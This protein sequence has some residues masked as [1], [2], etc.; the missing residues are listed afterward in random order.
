MGQ[1]KTKSLIE[2][3]CNFEIKVMGEANKNFCNDIISI[4]RK[5]DLKFDSSKIE[6][7]GSSKGKYISLTCNIYATSQIQLNKI[8]TALSKNTMTK[9]VL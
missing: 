2:F 6:M 9:F 8:Y 1:E 3:P 7:K 4:I 5:Y